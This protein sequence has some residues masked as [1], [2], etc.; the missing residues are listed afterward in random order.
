MKEY[1]LFVQRIG[2][3]GITNILI[4]LSSL[5]L[6]P[7][8]SKNLSIQDYGIWGMFNTT[9]TFVPLLV[10]LGLPYSMVRFLAVKHDKSEIREEFYSISILMLFMG[11]IAALVLLLFSKPIAVKIFAG[12]VTV[13]MLLAASVLVFIVYNSFATYFRTFQQMKVFSLLSLLQVYSM[14]AVIILMIG[15]GYKIDGVVFGYFVSQII[16]ALIAIAFAVRQVGIKFPRFKNIKEYLSFG[17]PTVPGNL[18]SYMV[19]FSDRYVIAI[20]LGTAF[21]G[22]YNPGYTLGSVLTMFAAPFTFLLPS[23][24]AAYYDKNS[25]DEVKIHLQYSLKYFL[26]ITIPAVFGISFLSKPLLVILSTQEIA[27][28]G[29]LVTPFVA[30]GA[31]LFGIYGIISQILVLEKKTKIIGYLWMVTAVINLGLTI[32]LVPHFGIIAAAI[33]TLIAYIFACVI[34]IYYSLK[35]IKF[36]FDLKFTFKSIIASILMSLLIILIN[37]NNVLG[38]IITIAVCSAAYLVIILLLKG[39]S[40]DELTFFKKLAGK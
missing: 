15:F 13:A 30:L 37:P 31:L 16:V 32:I 34:T 35:Y 2:L 26:L 25:I 7:V 28:Q 1:K 4:S 5:I 9:I 10:N 12:N 27:L 23:L 29:Y 39:I 33:S 21:V 20:L 8:L 17:I 6:L 22:Y 18:S 38:I 24:L 40:P 36:E 19:E 14:V 3:V 11:I